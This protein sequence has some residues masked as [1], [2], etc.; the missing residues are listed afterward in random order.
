LRAVVDRAGE[1]LAALADRSM[2]VAVIDIANN[3]DYL[4]FAV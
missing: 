3:G 2:P 4:Q 1:P